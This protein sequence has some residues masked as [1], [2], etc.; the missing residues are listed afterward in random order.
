[1]YVAVI[2][3]QRDTIPPRRD[4]WTFYGFVGFLLTHTRPPDYAFFTAAHSTPHT[5]A[6]DQRNLTGSRHRQKPSLQN[7][8]AKGGIMNQTSFSG[9]SVVCCGTLR[10]EMQHLEAS[11]FLD[12]DRIFYTT[13]GLHELPR[14]LER[15]LVRQAA[16]AR[17]QSGAVIVLY[18]DRCFVD[19]ADYSRTIDVVLREQGGNVV[20]IQAH[21]CIDMLASREHRERLSGG[22]KVY[23][24]APGWIAF[25]KNVFHEWDTGKAN[26][27]FPANDTAILL[28]TL[29]YYNTLAAEAPEELLEFS[30]WMSLGIEPCDITMDRLKGLLTDCVVKIRQGGTA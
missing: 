27:T 14:E 19:S 25:R 9:I 2:Q 16:R 21:N 10:K 15:Q 29:G 28:D 3:L 23:W 20:R 24:L 5:T 30:D 6:I 22:R 17:E 11:G 8:T 12:A 1:M 7:T 26:E 18:G 13:P 4:R